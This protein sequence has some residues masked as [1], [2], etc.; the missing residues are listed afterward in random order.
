M[1]L[2]KIAAASIALALF[3]HPQEKEPK[4]L[5]PEAITALAWIAGEWELKDGEQTTVEHWLP[6]AGSTMMGVSHT[7]DSKETRFF[8]FLRITAMNGTIAYVAQ[9]GGGKPVPFL[10]AKLSD[11]EAI[12][13]NPKHDHPQ[14]IRYAKTEKGITAT[15]SLMDGSKAADFVFG[16][17]EK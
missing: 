13:E 14:R 9:P 12:F 11:S 10:A 6:L 7:Y 4:G 16:R 8:E 15:I 2:G 1:P 5:A 3:V 17:R